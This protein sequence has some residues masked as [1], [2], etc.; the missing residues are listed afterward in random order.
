MQKRISQEEWISSDNFFTTTYL[1]I[2]L[3]RKYC[4]E[5]KWYESWKAIDLY[6]FYAKCS[7][8]QETKRIYCTREFASTWLWYWIDTITKY[9][10][11]LEEIWCITQICKRWEDWKVDW[12]YIDIRLATTRGSKPEVEWSHQWSQTP[13]NTVVNKDINTVVNKLSNDNKNQDFW[14]EEILDSVE[15]DQSLE[16][17]KA[18]SNNSIAA[19]KGAM[20]ARKQKKEKSVINSYVTDFIWGVEA[21]YKKH[22]AIIWNLDR[23]QVAWWI[24][25]KTWEPAK[26]KLLLMK[27]LWKENILDAIERLVELAKWN[28]YWGWLSSIIGLDKMHYNRATVLQKSVESWIQLVKKDKPKMTADFKQEVVYDFSK[29]NN[30]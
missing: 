9:K 11:A 18:V 27:Q 12:W 15:E 19:A 10:K 17:E 30:R 16:Q 5:N 1:T 21:I 20:E 7:S 4:K 28:K 24:N 8:I 29:F 23:K 6:L 22:W 13:P 2:D 26:T 14:S 3:I 25:T